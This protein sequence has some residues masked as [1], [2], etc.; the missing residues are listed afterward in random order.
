[1]IRH[2]DRIG[3]DIKRVLLY[4][5]ELHGVFDVN[6]CLGRQCQLLVVVVYSGHSPVCPLQIWAGS[7][8]VI[9]DASPHSFV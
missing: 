6:V 1:M 2:A 4:F 5:Q 3:V 8:H 7:E 9:I